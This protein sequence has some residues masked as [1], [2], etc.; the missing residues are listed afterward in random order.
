MSFI[1]P[2]KKTRLVV[3]LKVQQTIAIRFIYKILFNVKSAK[4]SKATL[5]QAKIPQNPD[6]ELYPYSRN[7]VYAESNPRGVQND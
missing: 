4:D 6:F 2:D 5:E 7:E 3:L 1:K